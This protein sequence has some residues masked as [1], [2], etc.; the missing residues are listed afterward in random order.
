MNIVRIN[1]KTIK[2]IYL[3]LSATAPDTMVAAVP[4]NTSW[5]KNLPQKGTFEVRVLSK[6]ERSASPRIQRFCVPT[7]GASLPNIRPQPSNRKPRDETANTMKFLDRML[8]VFFDLAKPASTAAKPRFM[9]NTR[10][11]AR[12]THKVSIII[13]GPF[14]RKRCLC[15]RSR[16]TFALIY[17][18]FDGPSGGLLALQDTKIPVT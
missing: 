13:V 12:N 3:I 16:D 1:E 7:K 11:E 6:T 8:T 4:Q 9:K 17:V 2:E 5:K 15:E 18:L 14:Q 10:I